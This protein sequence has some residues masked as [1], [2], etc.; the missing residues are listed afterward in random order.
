MADPHAAGDDFVEAFLLLITDAN[1]TQ[2]VLKSL[3]NLDEVLDASMIY[4]DWDIIC[5]VRV[6]MLPDLTRFMMEIRKKYSIKKSS[7][8]I[9]LAE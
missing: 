7:T 2:D 6:K 5:K 4:G 3:R 1:S 8:L 9:A